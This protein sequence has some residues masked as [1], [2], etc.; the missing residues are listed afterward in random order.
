MIETALKAEWQDRAIAEGINAPAHFRNALAL[1]DQ[2][3]YKDSDAE[4]R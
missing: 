3:N 2:H 4:A 1:G